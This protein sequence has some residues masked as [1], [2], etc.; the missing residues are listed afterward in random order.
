M[1]IKESQLR[2]IIRNVLKESLLNDRIEHTTLEEVM[3]RVYVLTPAIA[4]I[5]TFFKTPAVV[6]EYGDVKT[7]VKDTFEKIK[8]LF[9]EGLKEDFT[10]VY[11]GFNGDDRIVIF[12]EI[13]PS[14]SYQGESVGVNEIKH[15]IRGSV[16]ECFGYYLGNIT[17]GGFQ[18]E[19]GTQLPRVNNLDLIENP[20]MQEQ[21]KQFATIKG[22]MSIR[23]SFEAKGG[24]EMINL[25]EAINTYVPEDMVESILEDLALEFEEQTSPVSPEYEHTF[26]DGFGNE[27]DQRKVNCNDLPTLS[28]RGIGGGARKS[29]Y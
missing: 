7:Y 24:K 22:L 29:D 26:K 9:D 1:K 21:V 28:T 8:T 4:N 2:S 17:N 6:A 15:V 18:Y 12:D 19:D 10:Y 20:E 5:G 25:V 27:I 3:C 14:P 16:P 11:V 13:D 23:Y